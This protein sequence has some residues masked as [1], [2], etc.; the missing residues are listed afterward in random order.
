MT[1]ESF[2]VAA[3]QKERMLSAEF[4]FGLNI[5]GH[6]TWTLGTLLGYFSTSVLPE[7]IQE[8]MGMALYALFI[9]LLVPSVRKSM[10]ALVVALTSMVLSSFIKYMPFLSALNR[11][12]SIIAA[13][14]VAALIGAVVFPAEQG[15]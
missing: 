5:V 1:D 15:V 9:G 7:S 4:M 10:P 11:G 12:V 8:S 3:M 6:C 13:A 2:S 14:G